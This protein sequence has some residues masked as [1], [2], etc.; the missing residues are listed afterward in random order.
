MIIL[1]VLYNIVDKLQ[2]N[3]AQDVYDETHM[4]MDMY[5]VFFNFQK[6]LFPW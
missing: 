3:E 6:G 5:K 4:N 1:R 2:W